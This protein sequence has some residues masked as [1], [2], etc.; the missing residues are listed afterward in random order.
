MDDQKFENAIRTGAELLAEEAEAQCGNW[1]QSEGLSPEKK[2]QL[3]EKIKEYE[4]GRT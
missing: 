4:E 3:L 2:K 1:Q